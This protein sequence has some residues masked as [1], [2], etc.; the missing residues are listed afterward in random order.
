MSKVNEAG[1]VSATR[2]RRKKRGLIVA[3]SVIGVLAVAGIGLWEWHEQP[4]FCS[5]LCHSTMAHYYGTYEGEGYL[6]A[7]HAEAGI[8]CLECHEPTVESQIEELKVQVSGDFSTPLKSREVKNDFCGGDDCH[9]E[10][11]MAQMA[12]V[13]G[14]LEYNPHDNHVVLGARCSGC[15]NMHAPQEMTCTQCHDREDLDYTPFPTEDE[16]VK[17]DI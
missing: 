10:A 8:T 2:P 11:T 1:D 13:T 15:H 16:L 14:D 12:E 17:A 9:G 5:T 3:A 7:A 4:S 6:V